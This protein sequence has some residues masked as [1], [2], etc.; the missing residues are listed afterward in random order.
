[1]KSQIHMHSFEFWNMS[2][3]SVTI[4]ILNLM[5]LPTHSKVAEDVLL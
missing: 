2:G 1:M 4:P 5:T 3:C